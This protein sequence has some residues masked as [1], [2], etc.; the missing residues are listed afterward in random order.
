VSLKGFS[1]RREAHQAGLSIL[2]AGQPYWLILMDEAWH[3]CVREAHSEQLQ[4]ELNLFLA[5]DTVKPHRPV[6]SFEGTWKPGLLIA[7][8]LVSFHLLQQFSGLPI[9][10]WG[11]N[12]SDALLGHLQF[13]RPLT[14]LTLHADLAHLSGNV[15]WICFLGFLLSMEFRAWLSWLLTLGA[16]AL[17]NTLNAWVHVGSNFSSIG[18]STAVFSAWGL[19]VGLQVGRLWILRRLDKR[20][21]ISPL[22]AGLCLLAWTGL[23]PPP[24]DV[25]SHILG[26]FCGLF[27]GLPWCRIPQF[28]SRLKLDG[29]LAAFPAIVLLLS[30]WIVAFAVVGSS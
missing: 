8:V 16:A 29:Y 14:A 23:G 12:Q 6:T 27:W 24:T 5:Q 30:A 25:S 7:L 2:A 3:L 18:A 9:A 15:A 19:L 10:I 26:F 21:W 20:A 28:G 1:N 22:A 4:T 17:A 13:W 11:S